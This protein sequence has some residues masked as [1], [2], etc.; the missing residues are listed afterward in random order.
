MRHEDSVL[1]DES[2]EP[3]VYTFWI[4]SSSE[5]A[6]KRLANSFSLGVI[7]LYVAGF[8]FL[9]L[10]IRNLAFTILALIVPTA[11]LAIRLM[12]KSDLKKAL[13]FE[14][15]IRDAAHPAMPKPSHTGVQLTDPAKQRQIFLGD[16]G[17]LIF[18][19]KKR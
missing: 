16:D 11:F 19:P 18:L 13:L 12:L 17:E 6:R 10:L 5:V 15:E 8:M 2:D 7:Y 3:R 1:S 14:R 9:S 4:T